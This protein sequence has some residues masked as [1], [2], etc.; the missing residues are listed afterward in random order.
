MAEAILVTDTQGQILFTNPAAARLLRGS[1]ATLI[2][3]PL[4][5]V[6]RL[7]NRLSGR[8]GDD[9]IERAIAAEN[10]L[11]LIAEDSLIFSDG[12]GAAVPIVW[13]ARASYGPDHKPRGAIVVFRDPDELTLTP[14]EL[15]KANRFESLGL[16]AGGIAHDFNNLLTTIL[17]GVSLAK[18]NRDNSALGDSEKACLTAKGLTKQLLVFAKGGTGVQTVVTVR[19]ILDDTIKIAGA[20]SVAVVSVEVDPSTGPILVDRAEMLQVFQ[21]LVINALQAMPPAPH[22]ARVKLCA[23]NV[24]VAAEQIPGLPAG[25]YVEFESRDNGSGNPERA[26]A[27]SQ[28]PHIFST[29]DFSHRA[30]LPDGAAWPA[31]PASP[32]PAAPPRVMPR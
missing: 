25:D 29:F 1:A 30:Y 32:P 20:G 26:H 15:V 11:P 24:T 6:F 5:D 19:E 31:A 13:T 28:R 9:P 3:T 14:D 21:N 4:A 7:V 23:R 10:P 17:G 8:T 2:G 18:D 22:A 12:S 27:W 16:L